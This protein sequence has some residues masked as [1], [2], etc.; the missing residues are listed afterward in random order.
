LTTPH[1][2]YLALLVAAMLQMIYFWGQLPDTVASHF[3]GAGQADGWSSKTFFFGMMTGMMILMAAIF[4]Y[5]PRMIHKIPVNFV[6]LPYRDYWLAE[7]RRAAT[8]RFISRQMA[9]FGVVT[10]L[11]LI[12][13]VQFTIETNLDTRRSLPAG[14]MWVFWLYMA[15]TLIWTVL[16]VTHFARHRRN[17]D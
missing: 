10:Q 6:S 17:R 11:L 5:L 8:M 1:K 2:I 14:F 16:F 12:A 7:N 4:L 15:F 9:W 13:T 3:N